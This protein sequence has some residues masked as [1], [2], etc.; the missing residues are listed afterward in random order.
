MASGGYSHSVTDSE[1]EAAVR[2]Y[3]TAVFHFALSLTKGNAE[4]CDLVQET[5]FLLATR[6]EQVRDVSKLKGWLMTTCYREY[7]RLQRHRTRFPHVELSVAEAELPAVGPVD[8]SRL[9]ADA[10][11]R[12]LHEVDEVF[13]VPLML[14][15]LESQ[16]YQEIAE[17]LGVPEGTVMSRLWRGRAQLRELLASVR[18]P[19][20]SLAA[21][22]AT[23]APA[24]TL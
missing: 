11:M 16:S 12:A 4:A 17:L 1:Y 23:S 22:I 6:G 21:R 5:F 7:L 19:E 8:F 2:R 20:T 3:Y 10:V 13:R 14:F 24:L 9:D 15:Y 18:A